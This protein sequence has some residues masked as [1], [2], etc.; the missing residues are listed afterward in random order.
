MT[1]YIAH[2]LFL[3]QGL[4]VNPFNYKTNIIEGSSPKDV[5]AYIKANGPIYILDAI[6]KEHNWGDP[7]VGPMQGYT[8]TDLQWIETSLPPYPIK[9][10][11]LVYECNADGSN[12]LSVSEFTTP[13]LT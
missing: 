13:F 6:N 10:R 4:A 9:L 5:I 8:T 12:P 1:Y 2:A 3:P 11:W 7:I